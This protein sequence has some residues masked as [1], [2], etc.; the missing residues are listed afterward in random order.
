MDN[1]MESMLEVY[2]FEANDLLEHLDEILINCEKANAFDTDSI[3]E[4]FR[5]MHTIKGSSA[6]MQFN[7]LM[8]ISHKAEDLFYYVRENGI[9]EKHNAELFELMFRSSDF[10][11][12]E[13]SKVENNEP[14]TTDI[15]TFEQEIN[16]FLK[17]ISQK[18]PEQAKIQPQVPAP[19]PVPEQPAVLSKAIPAEEASKQIQ[20]SAAPAQADPDYPYSVRVFFDEETEM[21]NLRAII[22]VNAIRDIYQDIRYFPQDIDRN[23]ASAE[24][25]IR[26][27]FLISFKEQ[28]GLTSVL[29]IIENFVYTKNY[30]VLNKPEDA[31]KA[32]SAEKTASGNS[33]AGQETQ[34]TN[35]G[36]VKQN[37]I[38]VN[39]SKLDNLMDLMGEIVITESMVTTTPS[40]QSGA[41]VDN[42]FNKASRQ[43][44]KLTDELQEIVMSIRMVPI[45]GVFQK[46]NRIVR[47]MSKKLDKDV[48]LVMI[49]EDTEVD[50]TIIDNIGDPIMH[51]VRNAMDHGIETKEERAQTNKSPRGTVTLSAQNT[52]GE[53]LISVQ[54]DGKGIDKKYV[55]QK[56]K[57]QGLLK[58]PEKEYSTRE[59]YS[60]LLM[61]GFSTNDVV[62]EYSGRG[63][64]MDVVKKNVEKVGGDVS[65]ISEVGKGTKI[66]F[67]IPLTL[68]IV[69]GMKISVGETVFTI[70]INNIRQSFKVDQSSLHYDTDMNEIIMVRNQYYPVLR[71]HKLFGIESEITDIDSGI[72]ILVETHEKAYC[73]FADA[74]L[75]EQQVVVKSLPIYLNQYNVKETGITGCAILG[76][77]SI[78]LILDILNL[79]NNN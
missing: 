12:D 13:I 72:V 15:G 11:K 6:M 16:D 51:L 39:L 45:S 49:G 48:Q 60:F 56:A 17:K 41:G 32:E 53:I 73:I 31:S 35:H 18:E 24:E 2:L 44:R 58:K 75:G 9:D 33:A 1:N 42:N 79:Y 22:L 29:K 52:G 38:N 37:L 26:N 59:I 50:K 77:G 54:D 47:D 78:S 14:L 5:I 8:T 10:I 46:M 21:E 30:T 63:V 74:L 70:P 61:P 19:A 3:N 43:L 7:S 67:K 27:G 40:A 71:L 66:L 23:P 76:D 65:L 34:G 25:I 68:A 64:G 55:L 36:S 62:T 20:A 57:R 69:N 28:Q 4:I